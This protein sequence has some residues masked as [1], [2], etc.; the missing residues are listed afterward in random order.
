MEIRLKNNEE[1]V[2]TNSDIRT[3]WIKIDNNN[4]SQ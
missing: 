2:K 3:P 4:L 1:S